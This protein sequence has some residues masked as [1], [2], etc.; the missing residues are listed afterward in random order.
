MI[1]LATPADAEAMLAIYAP[2]IRDTSITFETE[3]PS[4]ADFAKRVEHY[5]ENFPWLV[6]EVDGEIAG[7]AYASR[8][9]ERIA[10][11]WSLECSVYVSEKFFRK[12][13]ARKLYAKL[14]ELLKLQGFTLVYAVI[15]L[16]NDES[17][18][19][20]ES[21]GF[22]YFATYEKVGYKLGR[23]K[24][25]GWWKL[26]LN[27]FA[28]EPPAPVPFPELKASAVAVILQ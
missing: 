4:V 11:Q 6:F 7:Y 13:I 14:F 17:V 15:N 20:H 26:Q 19:L 12:G 8:Y 2:Y 28:D 9:R 3:V 24:N 1:R 23:W 25:V 10:Y 27:D 5:L 22:T 21:M 16:P 18:A